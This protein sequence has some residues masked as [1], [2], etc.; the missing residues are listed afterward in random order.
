MATKKEKK[1]VDFTLLTK[2]QMKEL[3]T[4]KGSLYRVGEYKF[5]FTEN[6]LEP[7]KQVRYRKT[8]TNLTNTKD[9][10]AKCNVAP[11]EDVYVYMHISPEDYKRR[12]P[13]LAEQIFELGGELAS[14]ISE[15]DLGPFL[16]AMR[17]F[18]KELV[19]TQEKA[20]K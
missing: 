12:G 5:R 13:E 17:A 10:R 1:V 6:G 8:H 20:K 18:W 7:L 16:E 9:K 2:K 19:K 4:L 15:M 11:T 14:N 3:E